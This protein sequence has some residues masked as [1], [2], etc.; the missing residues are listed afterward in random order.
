MIALAAAAK[1]ALR[2]P[3]LGWLTGSGPLDWQFFCVFSPGNKD[4]DEGHN[5]QTKNH[6]DLGQADPRG[7]VGTD[8]RTVRDPL[9]AQGSPSSSLAALSPRP[10]SHT[11][12]P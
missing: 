12:L 5:S 9:N 1:S 10:K 3:Q 2:N 11:S 6:A 7:I 8:P 4:P